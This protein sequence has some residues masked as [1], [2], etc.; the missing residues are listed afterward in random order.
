MVSLGETPLNGEPG[1]ICGA[2]QLM[3]EIGPS[4]LEG[5]G[6]LITPH[7]AI[8]DVTARSPSRRAGALRSTLQCW[9]R[10]PFDQPFG[11]CVAGQTG[12]VVNVE[13]VH[14]LLAML[15]DSLDAD[16]QLTGDLFIGE[17]FRN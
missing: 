11:N 10:C 2:P 1:A 16:A 3:R 12:D 8:I 4:G 15:L 7:T 13:F 9:R 17:A 6:A 5:R 14:D